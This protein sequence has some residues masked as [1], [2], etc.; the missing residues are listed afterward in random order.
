MHRGTPPRQAWVVIGASGFVGTAIMGELAAR[1]L[2]AVGVAAPRLVS[3]ATDA[4]GVAAQ[5]DALAAAGH[6]PA[7]PAGTVAPAGAD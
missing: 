3:F 5:A 1:G 2:P 6:N 4:P 7:G